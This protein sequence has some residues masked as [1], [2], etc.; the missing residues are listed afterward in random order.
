M[1]L[2]TFFVLTLAVVFAGGAMA[3][4][5]CDW[6]SAFD[7][8]AADED[9]IADDYGDAADSAVDDGEVFQWDGSGT[10]DVELPVFGDIVQL[11]SDECNVEDDDSGF[12]IAYDGG[13]GEGTWA[14]PDD[15]N[16][17][18]NFGGGGEGLIGSGYG[19]FAVF[20][21][22][23]Y[24]FMVVGSS[25][26]PNLSLGVVGNTFAEE[27]GDISMTANE[28]MV[29][30]G[31][32][33]WTKDGDDMVGETNATFNIEGA[34]IADSGDYALNF[35]DGEGKAIVSSNVVSVSIFGAGTLPVSGLIGLGL[36]AAV[37]ALGGVV[38]L[39]KRQ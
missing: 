14:F 13:D 27:G 8:F 16:D 11:L 9:W 4:D 2:R 5:E 25:S 21:D 1:K 15:F 31:S 22:E 34:V 29:E 7:A 18:D 39:R 17:P 24:I 30:G 33:Q 19:M 35:E 23:I 37:G 26:G 32:L 28:D 10:F 3:Q 36:L 6:Q 12:W 38:A 20:S